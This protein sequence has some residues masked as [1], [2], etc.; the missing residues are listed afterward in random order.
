LLL[1][2]EATG[3]VGTKSA[4]AVKETGPGAKLDRDERK[5]VIALIQD[6]IRSGIAAAKARGKRL[7]REEE[8]SN[9]SLIRR[10]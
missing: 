10:A 1:L 2:C 9:V 4:V 7:G 3:A 6:R 5:K 8:P